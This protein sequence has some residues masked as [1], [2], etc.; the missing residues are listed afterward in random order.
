[1]ELTVRICN[2]LGTSVN[3]PAYCYQK[4]AGARL[5]PVGPAGAGIIGPYLPFVHVVFGTGKL[6]YRQVGISRL[7]PV[8]AV[9]R[10]LVNISHLVQ[11]ADQIQGGVHYIALKGRKL[12]DCREKVIMIDRVG[13][14]AG[15][16]VI[17]RDSHKARLPNIGRGCLAPLDRVYRNAA[18][19]P[20]RRYARYGRNWPASLHH[21]RG[22]RIVR[23]G[24]PKNLAVIV[25]DYNPAGNR[26]DYRELDTI[27]LAEIGICAVVVPNYPHLQ[28]FCDKR[29][30]LILGGYGSY[31]CS[32][33]D[34]PSCGLSS[35]VVPVIAATAITTRREY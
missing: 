33:P 32:T 29:Y 4:V 24:H 2:S 34:R 28:A 1:L 9:L 35:P 12:P 7:D 20:N 30:A 10:N 6:L 31:N 17:Y 8:L 27:R 13:I 26:R 14:G 11:I 19:R 21:G 22:Y 3:R 23:H 16:A 15:L 18:S 5:A 25:I